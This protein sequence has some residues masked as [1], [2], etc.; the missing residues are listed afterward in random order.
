[1]LGP[2][3]PSPTQFVVMTTE[4]ISSAWA[5]AGTNDMASTIA[6]QRL[7]RFV[8]ERRWCCSLQ[9]FG[10]PVPSTIENV[11]EHERQYDGGIAV[12]VEFRCVYPEFTPR[13]LLVGRRSG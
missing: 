13:D 10:K 3:G 6:R 1:M 2:R 9:D 8:M 4:G 7:T 12:Y 11:G 5:D